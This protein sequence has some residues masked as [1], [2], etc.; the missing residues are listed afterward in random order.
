MIK[1]RPH[2]ILCMRAYQGH[3]YSKN[4]AQNM[5]NI[6]KEIK[7]YN[8]F[9]KTCNNNEN[10]NVEIV[11]STD[12]ICESCPNKLGE[13]NCETQDKVISIDSKMIKYFFIKEGIH[14]YKNLEILVYNNITEDILNDICRDCNWYSIANCKDYIL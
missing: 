3:G 14:N 10:I 7:T 11:Y 6:I 1:I 13:N 5:E 8:K 4:F 9:L 12:S 2:H